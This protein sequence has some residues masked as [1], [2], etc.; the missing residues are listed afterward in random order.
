M[1]YKTAW[2]KIKD[3]ISDIDEDII[4]KYSI[5]YSDSKELQSFDCINNLSI[6]VRKDT[7]E[8]PEE[9]KEWY[10]VNID[11]IQ[12]TFL[13]SVEKDKFFLDIEDQKKS[14][15]QFKRLSEEIEWLS[16]QE[17]EERSKGF[18]VNCLIRKEYVFISWDKNVNE[19]VKGY[20]KG[21]SL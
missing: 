3:I 20:I 16:D 18:F 15:E 11:P 2:L 19:I 17:K 8:V 1:N 14:V 10:I 12:A 21:F 7:R 6:H 13:Y 4:P 9:L 5:E